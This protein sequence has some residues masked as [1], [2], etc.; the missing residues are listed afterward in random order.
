MIVIGVFIFLNIAIIFVIIYFL[1]VSVYK[2]MF[3]EKDEL[4]CKVIRISRELEYQQRLNVGYQ[5]DMVAAREIIYHVN[6]LTAVGILQKLYLL[7]LQNPKES[8]LRRAV[9]NWKNKHG[10]LNNIGDEV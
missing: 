7:S 10:V 3:Y 8:V 6:E 2:K 9:L 1:H 5:I 4:E